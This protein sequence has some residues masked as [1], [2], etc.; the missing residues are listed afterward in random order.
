MNLRTLPPSMLL[1][2]GLV[3]C[4]D[5]TASETS[6][7]DSGPSTHGTTG[8]ASA[9]STSGRTAD[10]ATDIVGCLVDIPHWPETSTGPCLGAPME[11]ETESSSGS[12]SGS[13][14]GTGSGSD[15][16]SG[17]GSD[18]GSSSDGMADEPPPQTRAAAVERVVSRGLLPS[19]VLDRLRAIA[20]G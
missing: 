12:G 20:K 1:A 17:S 19:D 6:G 16:G 11:T 5:S 7:V 4:G 18:T 8:T 13:G 10:D 3:A 9:T 14:S 2:L 15:T